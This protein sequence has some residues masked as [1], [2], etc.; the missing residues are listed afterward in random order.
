MEY[1][2]PLLL[3]RKRFTRAE[4]RAAL[5]RRVE[6]KE[7]ILAADCGIGLVA[8]MAEASGLDLLTATS[9]ARLRMM[10]QPSCMSYLA[11]GNANTLAQDALRRTVR[12][13]RH[14]PV[15]C[16][17]APGD[18]YRELDQLVEQARVLGADGF[19]VSPAANGFGA[20]LDQDVSGSILHSSADLYLLAYC[21]ERDLFSAA[22]VFDEEDARRA[23][24]AGADLIIAHSGFTVGGLSGAP[25]DEA[26]TVQQTCDFTRAIVRAVRA[27]SETAFVLC[28]GSVLNTPEAVQTCLTVSGAQGLFGGSVF[29]RLPMEQAIGGVIKE[30]TALQLLPEGRDPQ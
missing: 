18:P 25:A 17:I 2:N 24:E 21:A 29:D 19:L 23:A 22:F 11:V 9:E 7:P 12:M 16:G 3:P 5:Q 6:Q 13:A 26:R 15:L 1:R 10:G 30:L 4:I 8:K 27:E 14:T 28:H 20:R